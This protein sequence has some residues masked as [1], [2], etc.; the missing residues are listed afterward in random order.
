MTVIPFPLTRP[1]ARRMA[2]LGEAW[3]AE[4]DRRLTTY[5]WMWPDGPPG[6]VGDGW[7]NFIGNYRNFSEAGPPDH[8]DDADW[9][10]LWEHFVAVWLAYQPEWRRA[11]EIA[12]ADIEGKA[13]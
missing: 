12:L 9:P 4:A 8:P 3:L 10:E 7:A 5:T 1:S 11:V 6:W 13:A 2:K